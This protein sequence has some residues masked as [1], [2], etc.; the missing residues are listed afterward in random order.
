MQK[1]KNII[2]A[3]ALALAFFGII[4]AL[5]P[6]P[7]NTNSGLKASGGLFAEESAFDFGTISMASG[8]VSHNF[9]IKN[10]GEGPVKIEKMY[11][12]CMCTTAKLM[13]NDSSAAEMGKMMEFGPYGMPG[14]GAT[15]SIN[16]NMAPGEEAT[17]EVIFDPNA[18]GPAGI[19]LM[20]RTVYLE[21]DSGQKELGIKVV[22]TP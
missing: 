14:H 17:V 18:H 16:K 3:T 10:T 7:T 5:K 13:M 9:K 1:T 8:N 11:T 21:T 20:E 6:S 22:V 19:G 2:I 15:P 12:S 4:I